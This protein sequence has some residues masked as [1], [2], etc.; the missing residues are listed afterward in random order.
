MSV[1]ITEKS[2]PYYW[3]S[4]QIQRRRF[5]GSTRCTNEKEA[6]RFEALE[7]EKAK[8]KIKAARLSRTSLAMDDV[9]A[10]LWIDK[11]QYDAEPDAT[12]INI[13]RLVEYFGKTTSLTE[14][15]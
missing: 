7:R 5:Y 12:A 10:R 9:C 2:E 1:F 14:I 4:F 3:F 15:D 8:A 11:A 6:K 13:A